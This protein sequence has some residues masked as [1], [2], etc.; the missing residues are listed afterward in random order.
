M[1]LVPTTIGNKYW[2]PGMTRRPPVPAYEPTDIELCA[3]RA[4]AKKYGRNWKNRL[5]LGW[6]RGDLRF[7]GGSFRHAVMLK[8]YVRVDYDVDPEEVAIE[9]ASFAHWLMF[10]PVVFP[11]DLTLVK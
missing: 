8:S 4:F 3:F 2:E 7:K 10:A 5:R 1:K 9:R 11:A 6:E